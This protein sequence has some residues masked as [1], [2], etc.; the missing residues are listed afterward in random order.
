M[1]TVEVLVSDSNLSPE[2]AYSQREGRE[3]A[4]L[5]CFLVPACVPHAPGQKCCLPRI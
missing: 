5:P 4:V 2:K 1:K 3:T